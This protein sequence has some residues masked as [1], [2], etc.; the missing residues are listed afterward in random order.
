MLNLTKINKN[1]PHEKIFVT[2]IIEK[3]YVFIVLCSFVYFYPYSIL[4]LQKSLLLLF[5][6]HFFGFYFYPR[7][8]S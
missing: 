2:S 5:Y 1:V 3:M 6:A 8:A 7:D 4:V